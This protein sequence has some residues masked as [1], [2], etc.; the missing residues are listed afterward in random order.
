MNP[1]VFGFIWCGMS[2]AVNFSGV[3]PG[4]ADGVARNYLGSKALDPSLLYRTMGPSRYATTV[5][6]R[7]RMDDR[8]KD[9]HERKRTFV[10]A[11][12]LLLS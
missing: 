8:W 12:R 10:P 6:S 11:P 3:D 5:A 1:L 7:P 9:Q 2:R 4:T